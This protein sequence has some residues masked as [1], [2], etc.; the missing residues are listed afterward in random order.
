MTSAAQMK[1]V[2]STAKRKAAKKAG[3]ETL[4]ARKNEE[5]IDAEIRSGIE[6]EYKKKWLPEIKKAA[7]DGKDSVVLG[8]GAYEGYGQDYKLRRLATAKHLTALLQREGYKTSV[9]YPTRKYSDD[10]LGNE[11][12]DIAVTW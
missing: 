11:E 6:A 10:H 1:R 2:S 3:H 9:S 5:K 4:A 12:I 7:A 8:L